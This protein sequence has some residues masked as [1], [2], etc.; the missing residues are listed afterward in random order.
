VNE[1]PSFCVAVV[2]SNCETVPEQQRAAE[3]LMVF[4]DRVTARAREAHNFCLLTLTHGMGVPWASARGHS[5]ILIPRFD[6]YEVADREMVEFAD[7][8]VV[9]GE[10]ARWSRLL[11][12]ASEKGI[13]VRLYT[14]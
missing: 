5:I 14:G 1:R 4:L 3:R 13:P 2:G 6:D 9:V 11:R 7:A 12:L 8:V 10:R